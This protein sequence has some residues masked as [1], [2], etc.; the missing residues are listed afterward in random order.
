MVGAAASSDHAQAGQPA[1]QLLVG[2]GQLGRV[3]VVEL[4]GSVQLG[5][6]LLRCVRAD[7]A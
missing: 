4:F 1:L 6:T 5:V 7:P 3:A 2:R